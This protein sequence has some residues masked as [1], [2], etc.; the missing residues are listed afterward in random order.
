MKG[1]KRILCFLLIFVA[2]V[3]VSACS[4]K[5]AS[6]SNNDSGLS[7]GGGNGAETQIP[8]EEEVYVAYSS[9]EIMG[10]GEDYLT[11]FFGAVEDN[12]LGGGFADENIAGMKVLFLNASKMIN[13]ISSVDDLPYG[14]CVK[15]KELTLD[16]YTKK[17]NAVNKFLAKFTPEDSDGNSSLSLKI[18]FSYKDEDTD[19]TYDYYDF[20][21]KT[22]KKNNE[23]ACNFSIE[24]SKEIVGSNDSTAEYFVAELKGNIDSDF[25]EMNYE[26]YQFS[27]TEKINDH[28]TVGYNNIENYLYSKFDG[29]DKIYYNATETKT[30]LMTTF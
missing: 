12:V 9:N 26:C 10:L 3:G 7:Q 8:P 15:G 21:I 6:P 14:R 20:T 4:S 24:R 16:D 18:I 23:I 30:M 17:P 11:E 5:E 25:D 22:N 27:R 19:F 2:V 28:M 29:E 1:L 13:N